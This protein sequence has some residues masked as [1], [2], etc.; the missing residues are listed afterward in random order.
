MAAASPSITAY[1]AGLSTARLRALFSQEPERAADWVRVIA[2][3]GLPQ[4]QVCYGRMLLEG[5]G[6]L[7][8]L[9]AA[10]AWFRRAA[11]RGDM[12]GVNMVGRCLDNGWGTAQDPAAAAMQFHRAADGGGHAWAQYNLGHLYLD[13]RGVPRDA[14]RAYAYYL[15]AAEQGH[16]RAMSLAGR[17][18]EEGWGR[19]RDPDAAA[20]WYQRSA[21]AG[22]FRGQ[23]N[24][25][26]ML[27]NT[28][29]LAEAAAWF[30]RAVAGGPPAM[31]SAVMDTLVRAGIGAG[32]AAGAEAEAGAE[33]DYGAEA[34]YGAN[35]ALRNLAARLHA[36]SAG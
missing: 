18:C 20:A 36:Q 33:A 25:A 31:R 5:T 29:R 22:Y 7:K 13:G 35:Q 24:W 3:E 16:E 15:R 4:A 30:E 14:G 32:T 1:L 23:Y 12:D 34:E 10:L 21:E 6:G 26:S 19:A 8:D 11:A 28:G 17:C 2:M 9:P 27:L